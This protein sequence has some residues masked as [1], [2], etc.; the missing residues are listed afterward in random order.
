MNIYKATLDDIDDLIRLRI[1]FLTMD[2]GRL[3]DQNE[4]DIRAQLKVYLAKHIPL[5]DFIAVIAK[6][7]TGKIA[8]AAFLI[9]QE[10]PANPSFIT[11]LT[12]TLLNVVTYPEFRRKGIASQ[13]IGKI[14]N[15]A[16]QKGVSSIDL[17]ATDD[18]KELYKKLGFVEP[19]Y[20]SMRLKL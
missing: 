9:I 17:Y 11:G 7:P 5:E 2:Q 10:R 3:S 14:I 18:G 19:S 13:V 12:G 1:D 16:R 15:E 20:T 6:H 4:K 8:S